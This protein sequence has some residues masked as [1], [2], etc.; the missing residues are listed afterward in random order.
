MITGKMRLKRKSKTFIGKDRRSYRSRRKAPRL[1]VRGNLFDESALLRSHACEITCEIVELTNQTAKLRISSPPI[2][3]EKVVLLFR[4]FDRDME[5]KSTVAAINENSHITVVF[6]MPLDISEFPPD[7]LSAADRRQSLTVFDEAV[8]FSHR[9]QEWKNK[10]Y[11]HYHRRDE[12]NQSKVVDF[13][14]NDYLG[15]SK[16]Q[17]ILEAAEKIIRISGLGTAGPSIFSGNRS[18]HDRL[19][20]SLASYKGME[21]CLLCPSGFTANSG[22]F[23]GLIQRLG[24][25]V[26]LDEKDHASIFHGAMASSAKLKMFQHNNMEDLEKKLSQY[27]LTAPKVICVDG[28]YSMDGDLAP[29][30]RIYTLAKKY[31]ASLWVDDAHSF[32]IFGKDGSGIETHFGL[33]GKIDIVTGS[34]SKALGGFGGY[35]CAPKAIT[36][37]LD[38]LGREF[39]Y[40]T[41]LPEVICAGLSEGIRILKEDSSLS[42]KK[43]WENTKYMYECL[44]RFGFPI[45]PTESPI[46][47][48]IFGHE[49]TTQRFAQE[50]YKRGVFVNSVTRPAVRRDEARV[51]IGVR[52]THTREQIDFAIN[53][54]VA[55]AKELKMSFLR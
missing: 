15:L 7:A 48:L 53:Q 4:M 6:D 47:P 50:V 31:K 18:S 35:V 2:D 25:V 33:K 26:F 40:T 46:I 10:E 41:T 5:S 29:L 24:A 13:T 43:L 30:D 49:T 51:R 27:E 21:S 14:S 20:E 37:Y 44:N 11:Y 36:E 17:R 55:V 1:I 45:G 8:K 34:L 19:A 42:R 54:F 39:V 16:D 12:G 22:V 23:T 32:G 9:V 38:H 52:S 28:V 3:G